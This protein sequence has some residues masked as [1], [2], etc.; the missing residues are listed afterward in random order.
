[1]E[2]TGKIAAI[3]KDWN[4][5][6]LQVVFTV[7]EPSAIDSILA[8]QKCEKLSIKAVRFKTRRSTDA[9]AML[10]KCLGEMAAALTADKWD[11]YLK[12][13]KRYGK[14]T[15][16]CV[17][18]SAVE[19]VK[20]QWRECEEV[21]EIKINGQKAIQMLCYYGSST[22]D[23]QEFS[24]LLNGVISEMREMGLPVPTTERMQHALEEWGKMQSEQHT[25]N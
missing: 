22:Y 3:T 19:S 10:W 12:M 25:T 8:M 24:V 15:Y 6:Q 18:P 20:K 21:G 9:N 2:F 1:M 14:F 7:N 16:I 23:T 13:L 5:E 4:T 17:H 11:I